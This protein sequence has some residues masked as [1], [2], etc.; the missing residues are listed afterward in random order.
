MT[1]RLTQ[2][3]L[4]RLVDSGLRGMCGPGERSSQLK[5]KANRVDNVT[6]KR[7][8][9]LFFGMADKIRLMILEL[10]ADEEL[11]SCEIMTALN[12]TEPTT[13]HHIGILERAGLVVSRRDGKWV[14]YRLAGPNVKTLLTK[15]AAIVKGAV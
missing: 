13:S 12:L 7:L 10:V 15:G 9:Q 6:T 2:D 5:R 3:R 14:F 1:V 8:E 11:C 4:R